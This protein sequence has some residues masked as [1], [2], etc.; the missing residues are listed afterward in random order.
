METSKHS[1]F[2]R[3][4]RLSAWPQPISR[5]IPT[6]SLGRP[7][8]STPPSL[9][10]RP[11]VAPLP[12]GWSRTDHIIPAAY[13]RTFHAS[14]GNLRRESHPFRFEHAE[15]GATRE[16]RAQRAKAETIAALTKRYDASEVGCDDTDQKGLWLAGERW[17]RDIPGDK[18]D[19][20]T[21]VVTHANGF[22]K[23]VR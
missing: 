8:A 4:A 10:P 13:P 16:E 9:P 2:P 20:V 12:R 11:A 5:P 21:L 14:T 3:P 17:A 23:E 15:G 6:L 1:S 19:G 7:P 18:G 22:M